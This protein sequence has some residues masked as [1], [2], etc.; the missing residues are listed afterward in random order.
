ME[1]RVWQEAFDYWITALSRLTALVLEASSVSAL[2]KD[3]IGSHIRGLMHC[4][5]EVMLAVDSSIKQIVKSQGPLWPKALESVKQSISYDSEGMPREG[6]DKLNE[7]IELLTPERIE[8]RIELLVSTPPYEH[9]KGADG[10]HV[11]I[12]AAHAERFAQELSGDLSVLIPHLALLLQGEQRQGYAF[13]RSLVL[14]AKE[15]EPLLSA[16]MTLLEPA[17]NPNISFVM[18]V[19]RGINELDSKRWDAYVTT[20]GSS[21]TLARFYPDMLKTGTV[22]KEHLEQVIKL[23]ASGLVEE[24]RALVFTFGS[25]LDE[26][27]PATVTAFA[28]QLRK[29]SI[30]AGWIGLDILSMYCH[31]SK[32]KWEASDARLKRY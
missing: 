2:A 18:G 16:A 11:N 5:R 29:I 9:E 21:K 19:L 3:A 23:I 13:G 31:G 20:F 30:N 28:S 17:D 1:A 22:T 10:H 26:L 8:D 12:A 24:N 15:W 4:G 6:V 27:P 32:S 25:S 7:W 14:S